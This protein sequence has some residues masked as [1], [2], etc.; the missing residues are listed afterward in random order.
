MIANRRIYVENAV[1]RI[2]G[3]RAPQR[4][5]VRARDAGIAIYTPLTVVARRRRARAEF[6]WFGEGTLSIQHKHLHGDV[7]YC[8]AMLCNFA[9]PL[10]P[11]Y[12]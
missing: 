2:K 11:T 8:V 12:G 6:G 4:A 3:A 1:R 9:R 5:S 7:A 10:V